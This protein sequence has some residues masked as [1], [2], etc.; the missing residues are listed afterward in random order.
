[1]SLLIDDQL[2]APV[3]GFVVRSARIATGAARR[4]NRAR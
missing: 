3:P 4:H 2:P 1:M